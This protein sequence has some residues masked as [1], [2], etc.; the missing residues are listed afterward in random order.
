MLRRLIRLGVL[1]AAGLAIL[2]YPVSWGLDRLAGRDA[3]FVA[4]G[5]D[6][7]IVTLERDQWKADHASGGTRD[8]KEIADLYGSRLGERSLRVILFS[9]DRLI[10]PSEDPS[11]TL[12]RVDKSRENPLQKQTVDFFA[13]WTAIG[14]GAAAVLGLLLLRL[15]R[16][17]ATGA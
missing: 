15:V 16:K 14:G 4:D 12:L 8:P 5:K 11:I 13:R 9:K 2:A 17:S 1:L 6:P 7:L 10:T 3:W